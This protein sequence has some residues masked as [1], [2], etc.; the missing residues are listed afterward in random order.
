MTEKYTILH[1][2]LHVTADSAITWLKTELGMKKSSIKVEEAIDPD[3]KLRPTISAQTK[4]FHILCIE[5]SKT[6]DSNLLSSSV[7]DCQRKGLPVKLYVAVQHGHNEEEYARKLKD[8]K[9]R[10]L[11]ILEASDKH[12]NVVLQGLSLSLTNARPIN[13]KDFPKK[14]RESLQQAEQ[15][16]RNGDPLRGC[17]HVYADLEAAFWRFAGKCRKKGIW[18]SSGGFDLDSVAWAT[19]ITNMDKHLDRSNVLAQPVSSSLLAQI[20]GITS[21]RNETM[22]NPNSLQVRINRDRKLRTRFESAIDLLK[23][24]IDATSALKI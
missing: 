13:F 20:L 11:G 23:E 21:L 24:F 10:G 5:V 7:L 15:T 9:N 18:A 16:Y 14:Y 12:W 19:L 4:D 1:P 17:S 8:A 6:I 2:D 22:H 3:I